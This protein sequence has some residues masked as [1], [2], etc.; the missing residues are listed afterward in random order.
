MGKT[1]IHMSCFRASLFDKVL[2][3]LSA[4]AK[5]YSFEGIPVVSGDEGDDTGMSVTL[6]KMVSES[7]P[8][9]PDHNV[10]NAALRIEQAERGSVLN[11]YSRCG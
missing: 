2:S 7:L 3:Y 11:T 5:S 4:L 10:R 8:D 6:C 9:L 1:S